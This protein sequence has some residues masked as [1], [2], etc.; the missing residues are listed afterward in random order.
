V[1]G[2]GLV[3][4]G[5]SSWHDALDALGGGSAEQVYAVWAARA[6]DANGDAVEAARWAEVAAHAGGSLF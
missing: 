6:A 5:S 2:A 3:L 4:V 1:S